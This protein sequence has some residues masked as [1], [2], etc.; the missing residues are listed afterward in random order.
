MLDMVLNLLHAYD[1]VAMV[2]GALVAGAG[3]LW[4]FLKARAAKTATKLDDE[5]IDALEKAAKEQVKK[6]EAGK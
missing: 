1:V 3:V 5:L 2:A 6:D 4:A